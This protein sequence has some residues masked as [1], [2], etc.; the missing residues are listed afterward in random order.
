MEVDSV[1]KGGEEDQPPKP[2]ATTMARQVSVTTADDPAADPDQ[3]DDDNENTLLVGSAL[4]AEDKVSPY[5]AAAQLLQQWCLAKWEGRE[6]DDVVQVDVNVPIRSPLAG[7]E[8]KTFLA[9]EEAK[10][11]LQKQQEEKR[12]MLREVEL[13]KGRLRLG[14]QQ[15]EETTTSAAST[16]T[17][18]TKASTA[19]TTKRP[20]K[21]SRFDS[22]LFLKF[23]KPL[24]CKFML[25]HVLCG[26]HYPVCALNELNSCLSFSKTNAVQF[27]VREE[28]V[29]IGQ[30]DSIAKYGI[31]ESIGKSG[32][33][34][35]DDYGIAVKPERFTDIVSGVDPSKLAGGSGR[36]GE[37]VMR[38]GFGFGAGGGPGAKGGGAGGNATGVS[39]L[40]RICVLAKCT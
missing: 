37:E 8:L 18:K 11:Q 30:S 19:A 6:M 2:S 7:Q 15:Q 12:A 33:I 20:K 22:S 27:E 32:E 31:G 23:S 26:H 16:D 29:G 17:T 36:I 21:K 13:A 35:E 3:D 34:L 24:H 38:R 5:S 9:E 1:V 28:A 40:G 25:L 14:E 39:V 4:T 10:R